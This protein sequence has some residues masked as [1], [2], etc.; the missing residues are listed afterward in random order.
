MKMNRPD[1]YEKNH[2]EDHAGKS[3]ADMDT[4]ELVQLGNE[5][6]ESRKFA[7][8]HRYLHAALEQQRSPENLSLYALA[9]AQYTGNVR[10]AAALCQEAIKKEPKNPNHFLRLGTIYLVAGRKKEAIRI[11]HLGLRA[12]RHPAITRML[13]AL[14]QREKPVLPF[15]ARG[16]PLNKYLGKLR[17]NLFKK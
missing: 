14:G 11:L 10:G 2:A 13:Q 15:L 9:L 4:H 17:S 1:S 8:A 3:L 12:G 5:A 16:N 7:A 6:L